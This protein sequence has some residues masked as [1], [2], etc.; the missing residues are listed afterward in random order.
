MKCSIMTK[1]HV[2]QDGY[3]SRVNRQAGG[4]FVVPF[5]KCGALL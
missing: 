1:N 3:L 5:F 4:G 2:F